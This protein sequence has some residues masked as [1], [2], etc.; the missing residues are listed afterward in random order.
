MA[1]YIKAKGR[2]PRTQ[3]SDAL[4]NELLRDLESEGKKILKQLTNQFTSDLQNAGGKFLQELFSKGSGS[5]GLVSSSSITNLLG[6]AVSYAISRPKTSTSSKESS[7]S[8]EAE[9]RF[10]LS[11][12]Q[13]LAEAGSELTRGDKNL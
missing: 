12:S 4:R 3:S 11:R 7:R 5:D 6:S 10:R 8:R 1:K 9:E 13:A 2:K